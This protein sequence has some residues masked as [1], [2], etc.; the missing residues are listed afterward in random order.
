MEENLGAI[1]KEE[2]KSPV[3]LTGL[4]AILLILT[5]M[6]TLKIYEPARNIQ[7]TG[8]ILLYPF[9]FL[10]MAFISKYY[11]FKEARKSI[12]TSSAL[13]VV[14]ILLVM[15][16]VLPSASGATSG[17]NAVLQYV[18]ANNADYIG[19]FRYFYPTL[20]QFFGVL[21]GFIVS[22]LL[23]AVIYNAV[24]SFTIDYLAVGLSVFIA[25]I[26]DRII[27]TPLLF[28][29]GLMNGSNTFDYF[30]KCLTSEF[31]GAILCSVLI[32]ILYSIITSIKNLFKEA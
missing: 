21:I 19:S 15:I 9:T 26:I 31:M 14:F 27:F 30:I 28:A 2:N 10:I 4:L 24:H 16:C 5:F 13:F 25:Y 8:G 17:Y 11:G 1:R 20:G 7:I 23:Y 12:F 6:F 32:I 3:F 22:H 29:Q 18:F